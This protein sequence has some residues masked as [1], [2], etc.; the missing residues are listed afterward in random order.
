MSIMKPLKIKIQK[1]LLASIT[2]SAFLWCSAFG[3][4]T[5]VKA[6][7]ADVRSPAGKWN[8]SK[9]TGKNPDKDSYCAL[10]QPY[11]EGVF[12]SLGRNVLGEYSIAIDFKDGD[13]NTDKAYSVMLQPAP[14]QIRAYELMPASPRAIVVRL[15]YDD[16]FFDALKKSKQLKAEIDGTSYGFSFPDVST[17]QDKLEI[18]MV[19][20]KSGETSQVADI[21]FKAEKVVPELN[22]LS[23]PSAPVVSDM[24]DEVVTEVKE[25]EKITPS[26]AKPQ[27]METI[28][29]LEKEVEKELAKPVI[30]RAPEVVEQVAKKE[31]FSPKRPISIARISKPAENMPDYSALPKTLLA[32]KT[33]AEVEKAVTTSEPISKDIVQADKSL[34]QQVDHLRNEKDMLSSEL[35]KQEAKMMQFDTLSPK[36]E[37]EISLMRDRLMSLEKRNRVLEG[38]A[39]KARTQV[40]SAIVDAEDDAFKRIGEYEKKLAAAQADNIKLSKQIEGMSRIQEDQRLGSASG[41]WNLEKATKR[42]NEAER[43]IKRLGLLLEQQRVASRNERVTLEGMLFDPAVADTAQRQR[44]AD[45]EAQLT[46]AEER[47]QFQVAADKAQREK[48]AGLNSQLLEANKKLQLH[49]FTDK[50]QR[51]KVAGLNAQ[52]LASERKIQQ[53]TDSSNAKVA[54]TLDLMPSPRAPEALKRQRSVSKAVTSQTINPVVVSAPLAF[55]ANNVQTLLNRAGVSAGAVSQASQNSFVWQ[56]GSIKGYALTEEN[57]NMNK[58][59]DQY[60]ADK[61]KECGGDFASLPSDTG[62]DNQLIGVDI[63]CVGASSNTAQ[64]VAFVRRSNSLVAIAHEASADDMDSIIDI[65]DRIL[66]SM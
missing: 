66:S 21:A 44:L 46:A 5:T 37:Q 45:L 9:F 62:D 31:A 42:Y 3:G 15:G 57:G 39:R 2:V 65:R 63:A 50:G 35:K 22:Q 43:E 11:E 4:V 58:F 24:V 55:G 16:S 26:V 6:Q 19:A 34:I 41:D 29:K 56:N 36:A 8:I 54:R 25:K 64:S 32:P 17:G 60:I 52:L 14:G 18:C 53:F 13:F 38:E 28:E 20:L 40:D 10:I 12:L 47:I 59:V 51:E 23:K 33:F 7:D 30:E 48:V 61:K 1:Q 49:A 27:K